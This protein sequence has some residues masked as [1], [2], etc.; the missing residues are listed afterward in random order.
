M[1]LSPTRRQARTLFAL[2]IPDFDASF[3]SRKDRRSLHFDTM[4]Y[5]E[6]LWEAEVVLVWALYTCCAFPHLFLVCLKEGSFPWRVAVL[7]VVPSS[8]LAPQAS[9]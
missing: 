7:L 2:R 5:K 4:A 1:S 3:R 6:L 9:A 8:T